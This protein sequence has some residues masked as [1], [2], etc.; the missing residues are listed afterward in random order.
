MNK[1]IKKEKVCEAI[2]GL[3]FCL[4]AVIGVI[5]FIVNLCTGGDSCKLNSLS[6]VWESYGE[7]AEN[8]PV[9]FGLMAIAGAYMLKNS[10]RYL[11]YKKEKPEEAKKPEA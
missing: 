9:Y 4:P 3:L 2:I 10:L 5:C 1:A 7:A 8:T 6:G 11:F